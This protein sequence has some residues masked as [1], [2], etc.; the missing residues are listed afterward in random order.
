MV[1]TE[2]I[3]LEECSTRVSCSLGYDA[4]SNT[5]HETVE[6]KEEPVYP[7][8]VR[9]S[10]NMVKM[11]LAVVAKRWGWTPKDQANTIVASGSRMTVV[12]VGVV[13]FTDYI[14]K[15]VYIYYI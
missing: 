15:Y 8:A 12:G 4:F 2:L 3:G 10:K 6:R 5:F 9:L 14:H 13:T 7:L 1:C 11:S